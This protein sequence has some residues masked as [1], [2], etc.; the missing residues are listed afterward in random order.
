MTK[1][2]IRKGSILRAIHIFS[3]ILFS[4]LV[5]TWTSGMV[6]VC[7]VK[8]KGN[9]V[10]ISNM[11]LDWH[12]RDNDVF[13][14]DIVRRIDYEDALLAFWPD[15]DGVLR[16]DLAL[17]AENQNLDL[18]DPI[19]SIIF[20]EDYLVK[21]CLEHKNIQYTRKSWWREVAQIDIVGYLELYDKKHGTL[22]YRNVNRKFQIDDEILFE[23]FGSRPFKDV[24]VTEIYFS[25]ISTLAGNVIREFQN[26]Y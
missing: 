24:K 11:S 7:S 12:Y 9:Q 3:L 15:Y 21:I 8:I 18:I 16:R 10:K 25:Q 17:I 4:G 26:S 22:L 1:F 5:L 2:F 6:D 14:W 13:T 19:Q 23:G 20:N